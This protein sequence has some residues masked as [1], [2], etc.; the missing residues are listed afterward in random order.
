MIIETICLQVAAHIYKFDTV[1][2]LILIL[3]AE[4]TSR[5]TGQEAERKKSRV[6]SVKISAPPE[7]L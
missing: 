5:R 3:Q 2:V 1:L 6:L 4:R 7:T